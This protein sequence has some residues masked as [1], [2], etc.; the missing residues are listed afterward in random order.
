M[1]NFTLQG[2]V[3]ASDLTKSSDGKHPGYKSITVGTLDYLMI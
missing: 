1:Q 2:V 3:N